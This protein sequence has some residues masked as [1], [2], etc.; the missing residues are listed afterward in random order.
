MYLCDE[1]FVFFADS[2][3][4]SVGNK[5]E[6]KQWHRVHENHV[7]LHEIC[8]A[9]DASKIDWNLK[10]KHCVTCILVNYLTLTGRQVVVINWM[11]CYSSVKISVSE[12]YFEIPAFWAFCIKLCIFAQNVRSMKCVKIW[13]KFEIQA[14]CQLHLSQL[15]DPNRTANGGNNLNVM[16]FNTQSQ[17]V[18]ILPWNP[19]ILCKCS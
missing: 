4:K 18:K 12:F 11:W 6:C 7:F 2:N 5:P 10:I 8:A 1:Y 17:C 9:A 16:S 14:L 13:T 19:S 3:W 15:F